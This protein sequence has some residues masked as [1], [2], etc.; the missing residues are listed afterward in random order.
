[1]KTKTITMAICFSLILPLTAF[2]AEKAASVAGTLSFMIGDVSVSSDGKAWREADFDMAIIQGDYV[3]TGEDAFCEITLT[4]KTIVRMDGRS[5][6][7]FEK[8]AAEEAPQ[9]KSIFLAAGKIWVNA[10][11]ILSKG[12]TFKV[13]TNKAVCA[14]RG[15]TFSVDEGE[16]HTRIRV[17]KGQVTTWSSLFDK[18]QEEPK[19]SPAL[20]QPVPV[21]GPHPVSMDKW[22]EIVSALQQITI[23]AQG[24]YDKKNFD[25]KQISDDPWVAWNMK[26]DKLASEE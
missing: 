11:R 4:D 8:V 18:K 6:Q 22:V 15:T 19:G 26:R 20:S 25:P 10:R 23:D 14:I 1:M 2:S 5:M 9:E 16:D 13:R 17:H 24:G 21:K 3:R 7:Q 12:D